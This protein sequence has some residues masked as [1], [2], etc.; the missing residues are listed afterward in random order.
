M[1]IDT[2]WVSLAVMAW[3]RSEKRLA[4]RIDMQ[5]LSE[6]PALPGRP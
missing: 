4:T 3:L 5:T 6:L 2:V 1:I